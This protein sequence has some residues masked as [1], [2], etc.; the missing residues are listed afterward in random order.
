[1]EDWDED[2]P[3]KNPSVVM[4]DLIRHPELFEITG[5]PLLRE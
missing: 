3:V 5:F 4:P 1:M 2:S